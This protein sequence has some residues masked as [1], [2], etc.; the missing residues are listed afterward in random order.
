MRVHNVHCTALHMLD[1]NGLTPL[2]LR[3]TDV[4]RCLGWHTGLEAT[5]H[6]GLEASRI[7]GI[8][9]LRHLGLEASRIGGI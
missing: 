1:Y 5:R 3:Q 4:T 2:S 7:G 9:D 8:W 6:L